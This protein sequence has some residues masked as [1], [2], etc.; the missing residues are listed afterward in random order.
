MIEVVEAEE[1][2]EDK[3]SNNMPDLPL[4]EQDGVEISSGE[5]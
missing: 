2:V 5:I 4:V 1:L 3:S